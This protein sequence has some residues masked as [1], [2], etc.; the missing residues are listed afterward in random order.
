MRT[1]QP[2]PLNTT[3]NVCFDYCL[4]EPG[5]GSCS[6]TTLQNTFGFESGSCESTAY[7]HRRDGLTNM[8]FLQSMCGQSPSAY[9][10]HSLNPDSNCSFFVCEFI[11]RQIC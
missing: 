4:N 10:Y 5:I 6:Q 9:V 1:V 11:V 2:D 3:E 8:T 7:V